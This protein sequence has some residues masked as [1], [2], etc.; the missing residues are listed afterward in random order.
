MLRFFKRAKPEAQANKA[1][2][3]LAA[4]QAQQAAELCLAALKAHPDHP[5]CRTLLARAYEQLDRVGE[6]IEAYEAACD[7]TPSYPNLLAAA[8]LYA[9]AADWERAEQKF[10]A[11]V[12]SF[13]TS[14]PAWRGLADARRRLGKVELVV[15]CREMIA[16][17]APDD[18][19]A[20]LDLAEACAEAGD[21]AQAAELSNAVLEAEP[22]NR[23]ALHCLANCLAAQDLWHEAIGAYRQLLRLVMLDAQ[24][25][26][27][28][29]ASLH[30][31]LAVALRQVDSP[32]EALTH[33]Q[34]CQELQPTFLPAYRTLLELHRG[35]HDLP[36]AI[37]VTR[38]A[39]EL[40]PSQPSIWHDLGTL[41][42]AAGDP[43]A[44]LEAFARAIEL[45]PG[46]TEAIAGSAQALSAAGKHHRAKAICEKLCVR[47]AF[48]ALP[49]LTYAR[50]LRAAGEPEAALHHAD[51]ALAIAA[52][53]P[54]ARKLKQALL[55]ELGGKPAR[56]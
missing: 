16:S 2:E 52:T 7:V 32:D 46:Y 27:A 33:L 6:A 3:A 47:R 50:V 31:D 13:P 38:Q 55:D 35:R 45:K 40:D 25:A 15:R 22:D 43:K 51:T 28:E 12:E 17:L 42:L 54:E 37:A 1:R 20:R 24:A 48:Q 23:R 36:S 21:L 49:H 34:A 4:G 10:H 44:A 11:A 53:D 19:D 39:I 18:V 56:H 41:H 5:E 8:S 30:Y 14:L 29:R 26:P 9:K